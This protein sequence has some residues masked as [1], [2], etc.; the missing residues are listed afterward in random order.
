MPVF[1]DVR[2][3]ESLTIEMNTNQ[4]GQSSA[5]AAVD[6]LTRLTRWLTVCSRVINQVFSGEFVEL[7]L[8]PAEFIL[9][10]TCGQSRNSAMSQQQLASV[11]GVSPAQLSQTAERLRRRGW[12]VMTRSKT[13]R[14]RQSLELTP[15]GA[16]KLQA[17]SQRLQ[18]PAQAIFGKSTSSKH[19]EVVALLRQLAGSVQQFK[20]SKVTESFD[21]D[22][23]RKRAA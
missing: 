8:A 4:P 23:P 9:L 16:A 18:A 21:P 17:A 13:D 3:A 15:E 19:P 5:S 11:T 1:P 10:W 2:S 22:I 6:H 12:V 14:R 7:D 20:D